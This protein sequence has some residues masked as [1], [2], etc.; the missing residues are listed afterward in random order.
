MKINLL[1]IIIIFFV[2][3]TVHC[4]KKPVYLQPISIHFAGHKTLQRYEKRLKG[5]SKDGLIRE[6]PKK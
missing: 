4:I 1:Q 2:R 3:K 5:A 6:T